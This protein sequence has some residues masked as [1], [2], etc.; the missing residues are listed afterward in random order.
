MWLTMI[1]LHAA[2]AVLSFAIGLAALSPARAKRHTWLPPALLATLIGLI[3]F[4]VGAM[5]AHWGRL[6][7]PQRAIFSGLVVLALYMLYRAMHAY[8]LIHHPGTTPP[9]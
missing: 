3:V 9:A 4:V 2:A 5:A 6:A 7:T 1:L 8:R